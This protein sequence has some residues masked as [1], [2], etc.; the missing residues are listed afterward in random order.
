[1]FQ[2]MKAAVGTIPDGKTLQEAR[3]YIVKFL[4]EKLKQ[5]TLY[6]SIKDNFLNQI[7]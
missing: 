5:V 6:V 1:M 2:L 7:V 4:N 3:E